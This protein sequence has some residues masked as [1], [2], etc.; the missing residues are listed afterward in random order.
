MA[1][2]DYKAPIRGIAKLILKLLT[3]L[4]TLFLDKIKD[5]EVRLM[6]TGVLDSASQTVDALSDANPDDPAQIKEIVNKLFHEGPFRQGAQ[7]ELMAAINKLQ[8]EH[9]R[10]ALL[11][12]HL[13][14][15]PVADMLTDTEED[16][17]EQVKDHFIGILESDDGVNLFNALLSIVLPPAYADT[18]TVLIIQALLNWIDESNRDDAQ[19]ISAR[20]ITLQAH[21]EKKAA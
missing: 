13:Q 4:A 15:F 18:L 2:S 1:D 20:L 8:N 16:N 19:E 14:V 9:V 17:T 11:I 21:Y 7:Q 5:A 3:Q 6:A 10:K 12:L